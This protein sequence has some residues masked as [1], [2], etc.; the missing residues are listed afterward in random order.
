MKVGTVVADEEILRRMCGVHHRQQRRFVD[1]L[2]AARIQPRFEAR[3]PEGI[4]KA[5]AADR[6]AKGARYAKGR[7][8]ARHVPRRAARNAA[9]DIIALAHEVGQGLAEGG[10]ARGGAHARS[11]VSR[12]PLARWR[13]AA[14]TSKQAPMS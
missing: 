12:S 4:A 6:P 13:N 5:V 14:W 10:K 8:R 1:T 11:T 9:P 2:H 7:H 3:L